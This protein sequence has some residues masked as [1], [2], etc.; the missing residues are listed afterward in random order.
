MVMAIYC[1]PSLLNLLNRLKWHFTFA[2]INNVMDHFKGKQWWNFKLFLTYISLKIRGTTKGV[3]QE[4]L[5]RA[6]SNLQIKASCAWGHFTDCLLVVCFGETS[7]TLYPWVDQ[8]RFFLEIPDIF[9]ITLVDGMVQIFHTCLD[10]DGHLTSVNG[11]CYINSVCYR[12]LF[13]LS[14]GKRRHIILCGGC[15]MRLYPL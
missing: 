15:K 4:V 7:H 10:D 3:L 6:S 9:S 13:D 2:K 12:R 1:F 11:A 8:V 5:K 14:F